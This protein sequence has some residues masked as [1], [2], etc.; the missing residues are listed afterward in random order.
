AL[1]N[2]RLYLISGRY[3]SPSG[4]ISMSVG[5]KGNASA[6]CT[7]ASNGLLPR[8]CHEVYQSIEPIEVVPFSLPFVDSRNFPLSAKAASVGLTDLS[9]LAVV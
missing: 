3:I 7:V 9:G 1:F 2:M 6:F 4:L 5:S 8:P